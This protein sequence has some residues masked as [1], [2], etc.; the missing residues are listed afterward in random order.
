MSPSSLRLQRVLHHLNVSAH[1]AVPTQPDMAGVQAEML[2]GGGTDDGSD[3]GEK[4]PRRCF[5]SNG[6]NQ[7]LAMERDGFVLSS[8]PFHLAAATD[9]YDLSACRKTM[10]PMS[11]A[12]LHA[13]FPD[14]TKVIVF[15]HILRNPTRH[16]QETQGGT[17]STKTAMLS[18]GP[19]LGPHGDYTA[20]SGF[21]RARQLLEPYES[22]DR[23]DKAL[24]QRFVFVN[25][26][27]P[28]KKIE[29]NPLALIKWGSAAP[30]DAVTITFTYTHR[31]GEVYRV[32][33]SDEHQWVYFPDMVPGEC[34]VF[35]Q[36]DSSEDG[37]AR[38]AFHSAFDDPTSF[39][40]APPRES[41][42]VRCIVLFGDLPQ[43]FAK[44]WQ[45]MPDQV[46]EPEHV[47]VGPISDEW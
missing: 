18:A 1:I 5:I 28:L 12:T 31:T 14:C 45:N 44:S 46:L 33:P 9:L 10:Y 43:D 22:K 38:F 20:R 35:K 6:R 11:D 29:R 2:Y 26:W 13:I 36:F 47:Q 16:Q 37:R 25:V 23:I 32:L 41:M 39:A 21:T 30:R 17:S 15:D 3:F 27:I 40:S 34:I 8:L 42:E 24:S 7:E 4:Q 19:I